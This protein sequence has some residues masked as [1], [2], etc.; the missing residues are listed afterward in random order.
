[1]AIIDSCDGQYG[2]QY[3]LCIRGHPLITLLIFQDLLDL[4]LVIRGDI[5][6]YPLPTPYPQNGKY[7]DFFF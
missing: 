5:Q 7:L 4:T 2:E 1:M 6:N 3:K